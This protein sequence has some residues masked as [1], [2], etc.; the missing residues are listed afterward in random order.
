MGIRV[1]LKF[2]MKN[3]TRINVTKSFYPPIADYEHYLKKIWENGQLTNQGP[4][5]KEF[6]EK[7]QVYLQLKNLQFV[8]NGTAALQIALEALDITDGEIITT[9]F[10]YVATVS[11]ILWQRCKPTFVDIDP[12]T[13]CIDASKIEAAITSSTKAIMPVHIF[14][15][16]CEV[17]NIE[18]VAKKYNLKVIYDGAHAFGVKYKG[19]SLL[20][21]GD[22][23]TCSF[24]A[25]KLFHTIEGG[26]V[27]S[28]SKEVNDKVDL[29]KRFGHYGDYHYRL[30]IN[31]KA[32]EFHAA[33]GLCNLKYVETNIEK[34]RAITNK[35]DK[36]LKGRVARPKTLAGAEYNNGYYP[37]ILDS[38]E[39]LLKKKK[40]LEEENIFPRRYFYPS[41]NTL[42]YIQ[43]H[44]GCPVS[45][46]I[47][48]RILCLPLYPGLEEKYINRI[49]EVIVA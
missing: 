4:L 10:S 33:M 25:T 17:E 39:L 18:A 47:S 23:S 30:G 41:L 21:Y 26:A 20:D 40:E 9:P 44:Q 5:L 8:S 12:E 19:R 2:I 38:E 16:A 27:I 29:I 15:N 45:E 34:R 22:I 49:S 32:S 1:A 7:V 28:R 14:G 3:N 24:H 35:Y 13:F 31:A 37:V 48:R 46:D 43:D 6:E 36:L 11:A 42:P